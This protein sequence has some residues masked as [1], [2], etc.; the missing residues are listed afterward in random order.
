[1][2][3]VDLEARAPFGAVLID[4]EGCTLCLACVN[5]CPAKALR[6]N[7]DAPELRFQE[8]NCIQCGLCKAT[9]PESVITLSPRIDFKAI[10]AQANILKQEEP[11]H[12][13]RCEKPFG[14]SSSIEKMIEKLSEHSMF[15]DPKSLD[16]LRMCDNCRVIDMAEGE[17]HP[18]ASKQRSTK[19]TEDYLKERDELR[20]QAAEAIEGDD[21]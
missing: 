15:Q 13:V 4:A 6:D 12:C 19:T 16:R 11:F 5:A 9:C 17:D 18:W 7:P 3:V 21:T 20:A 2:D 10:G 1:M 8:S 14:V